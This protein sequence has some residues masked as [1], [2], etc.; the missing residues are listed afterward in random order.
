[1][2][3]RCLV[4]MRAYVRDEQ[5]VN[6]VPSPIVR[7]TRNITSERKKNHWAWGTI[8]MAAATGTEEKKEEEKLCMTRTRQKEI[9]GVTLYVPR[10][11]GENRKR[12]E[13]GKGACTK[14]KLGGA[15]KRGGRKKRKNLRGVIAETRDFSEGRENEPK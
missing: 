13:V 3:L 6:A 15:N 10:L 9:L 2:P 4:I 11:W 5:G 14:Q 12:E 1:M 7:N 8:R